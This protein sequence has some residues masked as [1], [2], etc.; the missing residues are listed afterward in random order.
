MAKKEKA[1]EEDMLASPEVEDPLGTP[2]DPPEYV[3]VRWLTN[4][5]A[6]IG[7]KRR[8]RADMFMM[9]A[10]EVEQHGDNLEII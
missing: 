3:Q 5:R 9:S 6:I 2:E 7:G 8:Y 4:E 10:N 1:S